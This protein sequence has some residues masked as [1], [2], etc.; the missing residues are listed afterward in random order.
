[1]R[2]ALGVLI[3]VGLVFSLGAYA[4]LPQAGPSPRA[5]TRPKPPTGGPYRHRVLSASS[6]DGLVWTRDAGVR[7]EHASVPCAV[8]AGDRIFLYYVDADRGP[9]QPESVG[10]AT[11]TDGLR[12]EKQPFAIDGMTARKA[13]DPSVLR[14]S[15]GGFRLYYLASNAPGDPA[16]DRRDHEIHL[17]LSDD[18]IRFRN[19]GVAITYPDLVDP[20]VFLYRS[21]W[22]MYVFGGRGTLIAR[23][24]DGRRFEYERVLDLPGWGTVAPLQLEDGRLRLY[25]FEQRRPEGNSVRS[26]ASTNGIDWTVEP[27][28]RLA[29]A[30]GEQIT[31]PFVIRWHGGYK[32]YFK[33]EERQ[34]PGPMAR[35]GSAQQPGP[36]AA[37]PWDNDLLVHRVSPQGRVE[38]LATFPRGG[39]PTLARMKDGRLIAAHQYFPENDPASFDKVA[40]RFSEDEGRTWTLSRVIELTGLPEG[41]R[42]PFDPTLVVLVDGRLRLYFTSLRGRRFDE[43]VPA[44]FSAISPD[45]IRYTFEPGV[46]FGVPGR[47]VIDCA[48]ALHQGVFHLYSPDNGAQPVP[49]GRPENPPGAGGGQPGLGYHATSRDGLGFVRADDVRIAGGRRWLG[50]VVSDGLE[51]TFIGTGGPQVGGIWLAAST[52]GQS[53]ILLDAARIPGADPGAVRAKDGGWILV[54]TGPPRPGTPSDQYR[55]GGGPGPVAP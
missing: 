45:G 5:G 48:V 29:A 39:V 51:L 41:M 11:S 16:A 25:A 20:D 33:V 26:F 22:F 13:L 3:A 15:D 37:G 46:R 38:Q 34:A 44:I 14:D 49:G 2:C 18:G 50:S 40:V 54:S 28:E 42:F 12:F 10:C 9:G 27:G 35:A 8:S 6:R 53:W 1:M 7:L 24:G 19:S 17:A 55:R 21:T 30:Q 32:M 43:D 23:S 4:P 52:D 36:G 31:D 47:P